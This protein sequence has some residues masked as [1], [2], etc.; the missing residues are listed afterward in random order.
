MAEDINQEAQELARILAQVNYEMAQFGQITAT[1][2]RQLYDAEMEA[3][4]GLKNFTEGSEKAVDSATHLARAGTEAASAMLAGKKGA[5]AFNSS[6]DEMSKA[7]TAA[8]VALTLLIPGGAAIKALI[9]AVTVVTEALTAYTKAANEMAGQLYKGFGGLAKSGAAASDGMTGLF[10]DAKKLGISMDE[11]DSYV[12]MVGDSSKDLALFAGTVFEGRQRFAQ[13]G[14]AMEPFREGLLNLGMTQTELNEGT[15]KYIRLQS[16]LGL[17]Q[18]RTNEELARGAR[19]YLLEQDALSKITGE[20]RQAIEQQMEAARSEQRFRAKIE[21]L[22]AEGKVDEAKALEQANILISSQSKEM[23]QAFRDI[24]TGFINTEAAQKGL[25]GTN[26]E[27][28]Q[29]A[30]RLAAGQIDQFE[31]TRRVGQAAGQFAKDL[32]MSAQLGVFNDIATDYAGQ[33][34]LGIF[35]QQDQAEMAKRVAEEQE[36]QGATGKKAT[37]ALQ[38]SYTDLTLRQQLANKAMEE[39]IFTGIV[40]AVDAMGGLAEMTTGL[41]ETMQDLLDVVKKI[42]NFFGIGVEEPPE[43][44]AQKETAR[45]AKD[46][47]DAVMEGATILQKMGIGQTDAQKAAAADLRKERER[48]LVMQRGAASADAGAGVSLMEAEMGITPEPQG[49]AAAAPAPRSAAA[50]APAAAKGVPSPAAYPKTEDDLRRMG[51]RIKK[52]DVHA[53]G[54][55]INP[56][57][58]KLAQKIQ[59]LIPGFG[60]F[61]SFNDEFHQEQAPGSQHVLGNA[62][63]FTVRR[64]P[65]KE[66]GAEIARYLKSLGADTVYDEYNSPSRKSTGGHF[67]VGVSGYKDGGV[68]ETPQLA[69][70]AEKGPEAMIPLVNGSIPIKMDFSSMRP[71]VSGD[72]VSSAIKDL[73]A[74]LAQT[75]GVTPMDN[76]SG[77]LAALKQDGTV[78]QIDGVPAMDDFATEKRYKSLLDSMGDFAESAFGFGTA[79]PGLGAGSVFPAYA[80]VAP[81]SN[82]DFGLQ[83]SVE[84]MAQ[85]IKIDLDQRQRQQDGVEPVAAMPDMSQLVR[86]MNQVAQQGGEQIAMLNELVRTARNGNDINSRILQ[87]SA[88]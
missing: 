63:D 21:A 55:I 56:E 14:E 40:P 82:M 28:M 45:A 78:P 38:Q 51:L 73:H 22:L 57:I 18:G 7:A 59:S 60:Y 61:S 12:S 44:K 2:S 76:M 33:V 34:R 43:L 25:I 5:A 32:N 42:A 74:M 70:V 58:V 23:G 10:R 3:K 29:S 81:S 84:Q 8:G 87:I 54:A 37:D 72:A 49:A 16:Q 75:V 80:D 4:T 79:P 62:L 46:T 31:A 71:D 6:L 64:K 15:L 68:A 53:E 26:G 11:L 13:I 47:Y 83:E 86:A 52:G 50:P 30:Q 66:E 85:L 19:K 77:L 41:A 65:T 20:S 36:K 35:A 24:S 17:A 48:L 9:A 27:L 67:H 88:N 69:F 39:F 1:T